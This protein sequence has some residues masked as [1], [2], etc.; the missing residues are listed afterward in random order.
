MRYHYM[1]IRKSGILTS[2]NADKDLEQQEPSFS[3]GGDTKWCIHFRRQFDS[4]LQNKTCFI[5]TKELKICTWMFV[6]AL[7][8]IAK[9]WKQ[10]SID[11]C[12][13]PGLEEPQK[14]MATDSSILEWRIPWKEE[15]GRPQSMGHEESDITEWISLSQVSW[16][17]I[18]LDAGGIWATSACFP[19]F[20]CEP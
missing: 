4:F 11:L 18:W 6:E 16:S 19:Q 15:P 12:S 8:I 7:L 1:P 3:A 14:G 10:P 17:Y 13:I 9:I 20:C 2:P 5:H